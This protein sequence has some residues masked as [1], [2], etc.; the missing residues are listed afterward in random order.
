MKITKIGTAGLKLIQDSEGWSSK[1]YP[2]PATGGIPYTIGYGNTFYEDGTKVKLTDEPIT[3]ERGLELLKMTLH[4]FER[5]VDSLTR[6]DINQNQFDALCSFCYNLGPTNLKSSTLLRLI[7]ENPDNVIPI[8]QNFL[9]WNRAGGKVMKGLTI[10]R[11]KEAELF[12][13]PI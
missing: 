5:H 9:K 2:D 4:S 7:N 13:K 11:Q 12:Y 10:R 1:P 8:T 6:D 3:K